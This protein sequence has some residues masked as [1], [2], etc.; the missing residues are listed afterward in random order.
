MTESLFTFIMLSIALI[1]LIVL[2]GRESKRKRKE[3][4]NL[5]NK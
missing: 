1:A 4:E 3:F 2:K 5:F